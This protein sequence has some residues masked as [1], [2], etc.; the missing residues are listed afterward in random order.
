MAR[1]LDL[2]GLDHLIL[3]RLDLALPQQAE[4]VEAVHLV[5]GDKN[6]NNKLEFLVL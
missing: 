4:E 1:L 3:D 2:Q 6:D 5:L